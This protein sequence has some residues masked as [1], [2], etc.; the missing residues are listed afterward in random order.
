[1]GVSPRHRLSLVVAATARSVA[2]AVATIRATITRR[3]MGLLT[4]TAALPD[5]QALELELGT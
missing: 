3:R 5:G 1:L 4:H 2:R